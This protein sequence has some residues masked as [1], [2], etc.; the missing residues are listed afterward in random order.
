MKRRLFTFKRLLLCLVI[1]AVIAGCTVRIVHLNT[2]FPNTEVRQYGL[3]ESFVWND[4]EVTAKGCRLL[5]V[6]EIK[7]YIEGF[8]VTYVDDQGKDMDERI[9]LAELEVKNISEEETYFSAGSCGLR[10]GAYTQGLSMDYY[11]NFNSEQSDAYYLSVA[12]GESTT[13]YLP[14]HLFRTQFSQSAWEKL[15][16]RTFEIVFSLYP[17]KHVVTLT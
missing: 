12:P 9:L 10:S 15:D 6:P 16:N 2:I 13:V 8:D 17:V 5:T 14:Y 1:L 3:N 11:V 4:F 7:E